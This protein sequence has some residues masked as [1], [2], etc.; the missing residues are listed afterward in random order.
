MQQDKSDIPAWF[1]KIVFRAESLAPKKPKPSKNLPP[2]L[3]KARTLEKNTF[4]ESTRDTFLKQGRLLA[5]YEDDF[6]FSGDPIRYYPTYQSLTDDELRGYFAW[7]SR[8][9]KGIFADGP[10]TFVFLYI[11]E[12]LNNIGVPDTPLRRTRLYAGRSY[13]PLAQRLCDL[14]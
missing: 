2:L 3:R 13:G 8:I 14:L 1:S 9:R 6:E 5:D 7:R 4:T 11:Y 10:A 12:L